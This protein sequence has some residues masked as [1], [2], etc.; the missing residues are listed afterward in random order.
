MLIRKYLRISAMIPKQCQCRKY[1]Y[2]GWYHPPNGIKPIRQNTTA[3]VLG[4]AGSQ[5]KYVQVYSKLFAQEFGIGA[6]GYTL[7]ME[8]IFGYDQEAQRKLAE[9]AIQVLAKE[10]T[11]K[12]I[13]VH[14][15]SNN[16][17]NFYKHVSQ[18]LKSKP[19]G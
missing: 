5:P 7:P 10:N 11:G 19:Q 17:F 13:I 2:D 6:H 16:G 4:W 9:E 3:L 12:N 15:F 14:C 8:L 1:H 18:L